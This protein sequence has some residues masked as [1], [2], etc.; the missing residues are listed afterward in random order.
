[1]VLDNTN[2]FNSI[3]VEPTIEPRETNVPVV[4]LNEYEYPSLPTTTNKPVFQKESNNAWTKK[5]RNKFFRS[6]NPSKKQNI[7][8]T[9]TFETKV[10]ENNFINVYLPC[11]RRLPPS[12]IRKKLSFMGIDN[13]Q[14]LDTYCPDWDTVLLLIHEKY[15]ETF[16]AKIEKAGISQKYYDYLHVSHLRDPKY[17]DLTDVEKVEK[18]K[19]IR[20]N[21]SMRAL[22]YIRN[23]VKKTVARCFYRK[24][25]IS[26]E[27]LKQVLT[28]HRIED[29]RNTFSNDNVNN[30]EEVLVKEAENNNMEIDENENENVV[31]E[32]NILDQSS[33]TEE[34]T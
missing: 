13:V 8:A 24:E 31:A 9:R 25:F 10:E 32:K 28:G 12:E 18:L 20:N 5:L 33:S 22:T 30:G 17:K 1:M 3:A 23:P 15:K 16:E 2:R 7:A 34:L 19:Q 11:K 27:Q 14:V 29:V 4:A 21:C 26:E 6:N